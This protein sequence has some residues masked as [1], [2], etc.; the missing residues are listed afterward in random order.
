MYFNIFKYEFKACLANMPLSTKTLSRKLVNISH[1]VITSYY[2][3]A[4][5]SNPTLKRGL[6]NFPH[7]SCKTPPLH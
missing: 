1:T 3:F 7:L 6:Y 4:I 2:V 5:T